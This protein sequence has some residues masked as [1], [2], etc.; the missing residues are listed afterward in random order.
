MSQNGSRTKVAT[1]QDYISWIED[2]LTYRG[3]IGLK[4]WEPMPQDI[5][6]LIPIPDLG[7][8]ELEAG[9]FDLNSCLGKAVRDAE[10]DKYV[11]SL[12]LKHRNL[13]PGALEILDNTIDREIS[14]PAVV[15]DLK[16]ADAKLADKI[17]GLSRNKLLPS[18]YTIHLLSS[19]P[20]EGRLLSGLDS[21]IRTFQIPINTC[22]EDFVAKLYSE[23]LIFWPKGHGVNQGYNLENSPWTYCLLSDENGISSMTRK[24][25]RKSDYLALLQYLSQDAIGKVVLWHASSVVTVR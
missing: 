14:D 1:P 10:R 8:G 15:G 22:F 21:R 20:K 2:W 12:V 4:T 16:R 18:G 25:A 5:A 17:I 19:R 6:D 23:S 7:D 9:Y 13:A 24:I 11:Q 3:Q